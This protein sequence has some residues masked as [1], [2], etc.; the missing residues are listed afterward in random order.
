MPP[1]DDFDADYL[2]VGGGPAGLIAATYLGRFRRR[3]L[4]VDDGRSRARWIPVSHN[5][6]G[7]PDGI[8]GR[9]LLERLGTQ[10]QRYGAGH[11]DGTVAAIVPIPDGF[12]AEVGASTIR[13]RRVILATGVVDRLPPMDGIDAAISTGRVRL[14]PVCDGYEA[15]GRS[16]AVLGPPERALKEALFLTAFTD[17]LTLLR[18]DEHRSADADI[19]A[20]CRAAG[21]A[22]ERAPVRTLDPAGDGIAATLDDDRVLRFD[23]L[24]PAM[25]ITPTS[26]LAEELGARTAPTG[27]I[28]TDPH[29]LTTIPGLYAAGDVVNELNQISVAAG[30]AAIAATHVHNALTAEDRAR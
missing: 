11:L 6:P 25:G 9:R 28:E 8:G 13:A 30:H 23:S 27:C 21:I 22:V 2:I 17:R 24:Y 26:A 7:F 29:Q 20:R 18:L 19:L 5:M 15:A 1:A 4:I 12:E 3:A 16:V 14:C 10:A